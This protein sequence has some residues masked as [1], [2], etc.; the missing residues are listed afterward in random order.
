MEN[1]P[2]INPRGKKREKVELYKSMTKLCCVIAS[3]LHFNLRKTKHGNMTTLKY[4]QIVHK[5]RKQEKE[6]GIYFNPQMV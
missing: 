3:F 4:Q 2:H 1:Y 6:C 5:Y